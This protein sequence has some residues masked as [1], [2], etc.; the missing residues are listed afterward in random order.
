[1]TR[2][3]AANPSAAQIRKKVDRP[4]RNGITIDDAIRSGSYDEFDS[5]TNNT[6]RN[7]ESL[8]NSYFSGAHSSVIMKEEMN[9]KGLKR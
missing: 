7:S 3:D 2:S 9:L 5:A 4:S 1:M 6:H 8:R